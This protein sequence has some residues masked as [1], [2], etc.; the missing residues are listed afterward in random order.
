MIYIFVLYFCRRRQNLTAERRESQQT[1]SVWTEVHCESTETKT[2]D[3]TGGRFCAG[4]WTP[5]PPPP[6]TGKCLV[7]CRYVSV[8]SPGICIH[9]FFKLYWCIYYMQQRNMGRGRGGDGA[10][11]RASSKM[12][13]TTWEKQKNLFQGEAAVEFKSGVMRTAARRGLNAFFPTCPQEPRNLVFFSR[14]FV[15][16]KT[17]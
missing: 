14:S 11:S 3:E 16:P 1:N 7:M 5:P 15:S 6:Q 4:I 9:S 10:E 2:A 8:G 13:Q 12:H 17:G